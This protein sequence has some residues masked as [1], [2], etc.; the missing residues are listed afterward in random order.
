MESDRLRLRPL[1]PTDLQD[2]QGLWN[3]PDVRRYLWENRRMSHEDIS[4]IIDE[5]RRLHAA[6]GAGLWMVERREAPGVVGFGGYWYFGE[7]AELRI[8]FGLKPEHWGLGLATDLARCLIRYGFDTLGLDRITGATHRAN[9]SSQRV[10]E[11]AGIPT[12]PR[13]PRAW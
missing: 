4:G 6:S 5:S 10:M 2:V 12:E 11:K 1:D 3:D 13:W 7:P 8:L 9:V